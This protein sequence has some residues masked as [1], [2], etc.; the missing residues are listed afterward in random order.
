M[1]ICTILVGSLGSMGVC[2]LP[3]WSS[4]LMRTVIVHICVSLFLSRMGVGARARLRAKNGDI[5]EHPHLNHQW[6]CVSTLAS[7]LLRCAESELNSMSQAFSF[8]IKLTPQ[9][10]TIL[11]PFVRAELPRN[12]PL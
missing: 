1:L 10:E 7:Y 9:G 8:R 4:T 2:P 5:Q 6:H 11:Y 3:Y 12:E